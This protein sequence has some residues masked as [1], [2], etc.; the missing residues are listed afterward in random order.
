MGT[1]QMHI[2]WQSLFH[3]KASE[4]QSVSSSGRDRFISQSCDAMLGM[5]RWR[6][7]EEVMGVLAQPAFQPAGSPGKAQSGE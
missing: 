4:A 7:E 3:T 1:C 5:E 2:V 6:Q